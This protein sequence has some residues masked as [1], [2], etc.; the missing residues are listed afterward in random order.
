[1]GT[2]GWYVERNGFWHGAVG[3]AACWAGRAAGLVDAAHVVSRV[4]EVAFYRRQSHAEHDLAQVGGE[5]PES[6]IQR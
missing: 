3:P 1:M 2:P 6:Q 4:A 5:P